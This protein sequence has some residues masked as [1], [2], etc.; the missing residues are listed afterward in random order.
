VVT[1]GGVYEVSKLAG[2]LAHQ[3]AQVKQLTEFTAVPDVSTVFLQHFLRVDGLD[4]SIDVLI[5]PACTRSVPVTFACLSQKNWLA[6]QAPGYP[7]C[8]DTCLLRL[9][10]VRGVGGAHSAP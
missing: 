9:L 8:S 2:K 10:H 6:C 3:V 4:S 7:G 5:A 1:V